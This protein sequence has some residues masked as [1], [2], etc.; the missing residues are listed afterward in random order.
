VDAIY[1][2]TVQFEEATAIRLLIAE[3]DPV[4]NLP[5]GGCRN[6][7]TG[8]RH[9]TTRSRCCGRAGCWPHA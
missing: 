8:W 1:E 6:G 2:I 9:R 3:D 5:A 4:A 7:S